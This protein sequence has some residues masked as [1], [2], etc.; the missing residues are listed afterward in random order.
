V[1]RG[2]GDEVPVTVA[3]ADRDDA[4][5]HLAGARLAQVDLLDAERL[6]HAVED[7]RLNLHAH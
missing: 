6:V 2:A 5:E 4:H 3:D 1:L 7:R